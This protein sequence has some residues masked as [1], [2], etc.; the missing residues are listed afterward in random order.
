MI[1]DVCDHKNNQKT[2]YKY[3]Y[4]DLHVQIWK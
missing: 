2:Y 1:N 4:N 3:D